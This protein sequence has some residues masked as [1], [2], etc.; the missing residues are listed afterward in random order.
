MMRSASASG[1]AAL[2]LRRLMAVPRTKRP[3]ANQ[4]EIDGYRGTSRRSAL[5]CLETR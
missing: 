3:F 4:R 5:R 1:R 2:A